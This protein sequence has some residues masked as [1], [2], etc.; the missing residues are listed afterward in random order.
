MQIVID[1]PDSLYENILICW[2][3]IHPKVWK[4]LKDG[5][6][7]PKGHGRIADIDKVCE[8]ILSESVSLNTL[9][10]GFDRN[11]R[12]KITESKSNKVNPAN[13]YEIDDDLLELAGLKK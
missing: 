11:S 2:E 3:N 4:I 13:G 6:V 8:T 7:L 5:T 9:P 10:Y 12:I 1:I